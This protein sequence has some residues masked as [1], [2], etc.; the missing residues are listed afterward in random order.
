MQLCLARCKRAGSDPLRDCH[1]PRSSPPPG[2][3]RAIGPTFNLSAD[4][5]VN[6]A[7][8]PRSTGGCPTSDQTKRY[9]IKPDGYNR[10]TIRFPCVLS[11]I[12]G[13]A[14]RLGL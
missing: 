5:I 11:R 14:S 3:M 6:R 1:P 8:W 4:T 13:Q 10:R 7:A 2:Q 9:P 12:A